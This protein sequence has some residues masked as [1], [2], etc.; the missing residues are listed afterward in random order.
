MWATL[1]I[2]FDAKTYSNLAKWAHE[3]S[4]TIDDAA[5]CILKMSSDLSTVKARCHSCLKVLGYEEVVLGKCLSCQI[6][7]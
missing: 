4:V 7:M 6:P 1:T 3:N 5:S 2:E